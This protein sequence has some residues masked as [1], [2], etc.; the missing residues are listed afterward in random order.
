MLVRRGECRDLGE[1]GSEV[2]VLLQAGS[3]SRING[4]VIIPNT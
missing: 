4:F 3:S 2:A 1:D